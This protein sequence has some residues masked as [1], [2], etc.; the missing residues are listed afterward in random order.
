M[1][2]TGVVETPLDEDE[3]ERGAELFAKRGLE[4]VVIGFLYSFLNND[5]E[6]RAKEIVRRVMPDA[7]ICAPPRW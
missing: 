5:H 1:P 3:V 2:P 4:A 7:F 6:M